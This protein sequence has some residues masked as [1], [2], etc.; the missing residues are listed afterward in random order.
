[1]NVFYNSHHYPW[2]AVVFQNKAALTQISVP[3][4]V[5]CE[6]RFSVVPLHLPPAQGKRFKITCH[7]EG[8]YS[9]YLYWSGE[10]KPRFEMVKLRSF[11]YSYFEKGCRKKCTRRSRKVF[12]V[13]CSS[14]KFETMAGE[15]MDICLP[16]LK[17]RSKSRFDS[18]S[19]R[20]SVL[21]ISPYYLSGLSRARFSRPFWKKL[22]MNSQV[23][24]VEKNAHAQR[25]QMRRSLRS[26]EA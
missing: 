6:L 3:M 19:V 23:N 2:T 17:E 4:P 11:V 22:K 7:L 14:Q 24:R 10:Y 5:I 1:M 16:V 20:N 15:A 18:Y 21:N 26:S 9:S 25:V 13:L 8:F 12:W